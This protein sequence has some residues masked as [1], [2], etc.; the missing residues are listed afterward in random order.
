MID[1][2]TEQILGFRPDQGD[3]RVTGLLG[4]DRQTVAASR[5]TGNQVEVRF[6]G[7]VPF[8]WVTTRILDDGK[9]PLGF[10]GAITRAPDLMPIAVKQATF[11]Q[12]VNSRV[13]RD[14]VA[15][16]GPTLPVLTAIPAGEEAGQYESA[17][18]TTWTWNPSP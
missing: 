5:V 12:A 4:A 11:A 3:A 7:G 6:E 1:F 14:L 8:R 9:G 18:G 2:T 13:V 16:L 17:G 10:E 15:Y